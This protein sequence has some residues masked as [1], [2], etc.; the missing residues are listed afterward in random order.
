MVTV[1]DP[2][3]RFT[4]YGEKNRRRDLRASMLATLDRLADIT[5]RSDHAH[6]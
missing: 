3:T 2:G 5:E 1:A 6:Q 4:L